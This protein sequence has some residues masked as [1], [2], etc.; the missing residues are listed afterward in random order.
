[1]QFFIFIIPNLEDLT[2]RNIDVGQ[3][4]PEKLVE[5]GWGAIHLMEES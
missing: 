4:A 1:M 2:S 5:V 3:V